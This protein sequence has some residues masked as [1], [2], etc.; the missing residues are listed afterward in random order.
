MG[1]AG[2]VGRMVAIL[3]CDASRFAMEAKSALH[4]ILSPGK[5][6]KNSVVPIMLFTTGGS[7]AKSGNIV[8]SCFFPE[9]QMMP[10]D[11]ACQGVMGSP[12]PWWTD[13]Y[14]LSCA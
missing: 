11:A 9:L 12:S 4:S 13:K 10:F 14:I 7:H 3:S 6:R 8:D 5:P 1:L 2:G